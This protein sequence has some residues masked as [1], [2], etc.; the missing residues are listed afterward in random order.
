MS[1]RLTRLAQP[2]AL[3]L[4]PLLAAQGYR[5]RSR[6]P[7]LPEAATTAGTAPARDERDGEPALRLAVLGDSVAAGVGVSDNA[8]GIAGQVAVA[9]AERTGRAVSWRVSARSGATAR[10]ITKDLVAGLSA[11]DWRP[12]ALL[13]SVGIN[14]LLELRGLTAWRADLAELVLAVW[15]RLGSRTPVLVTGMPPL[16]LFPSLPQPLRGVFAAR[17]RLMDVELARIGLAP[18]VRHVPMPLDQISL[19]PTTFFASD[20]FHPSA[21]GCRELAQALAPALAELLG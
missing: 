8:D 18:G 15:A 2:A 3:F 19:A 10:Q 6:T 7:R 17:A 12:D 21:V 11:P 14:D 9:L 13:I 4:L 1:L 16:A 5:V 20:R